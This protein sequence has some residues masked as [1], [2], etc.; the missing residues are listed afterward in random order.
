MMRRVVVMPPRFVFRARSVR[1]TPTPINVQDRIVFHHIVE[2]SYV[3]R[4]IPQ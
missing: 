3:P 4:A 2:R 1:Y